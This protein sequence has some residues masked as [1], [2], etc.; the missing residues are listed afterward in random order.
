MCAVHRAASK[1]VAV[2]VPDLDSVAWSPPIAHP[3]T[4]ESIPSKTEPAAGDD[5]LTERDLNPDEEAYAQQV[6]EISQTMGE[7]FRRV[8]ELLFELRIGQDDWTIAVRSELA[9]WQLSYSETVGVVLPTIFADVHALF[10][11]AL[12]RFVQAA[13]ALSY[14]IDNLDIASIEYGGRLMSEGKDLIEQAPDVLNEVMATR[15][16][17]RSRLGGDGI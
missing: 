7:S 9:I 13:A 3:E 8:G 1:L 12:D 16:P 17:C 2:V 15:L 14:G 10:V 4:P 6:G 11:A 5:R